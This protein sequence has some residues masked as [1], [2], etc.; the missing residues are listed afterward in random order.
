M[1]ALT[2]QR[3]EPPTAIRGR[4]LERFVEQWFE[5]RPILAFDNCHPRLRHDP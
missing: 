1:S 5:R 3:V 2:T 4:K